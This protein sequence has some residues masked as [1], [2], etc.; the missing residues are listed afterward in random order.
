AVSDHV[1][2]NQAKHVELR[3]QV[4]EYI[5]AHETDFAPF[6]EDDMGFKEYCSSMR[7]DGTWGGHM[8]LQAVSLLLKRNICIHQLQQPRWNI[9]NF[10]DANTSTIHLS[11]HDGGHYSSVRM[12]GD[13]GFLKCIPPHVATFVLSPSPLFHPP[14]TAHTTTG[15]TTTACGMRGVLGL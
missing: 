8:E 12:E 14:S 4:V 7:E 13:V 6:V 9:V 11:Y 1:F 2:G 10:D 15:I 5:E 3:Q